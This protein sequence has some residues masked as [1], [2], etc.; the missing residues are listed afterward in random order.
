MA[1][2]VKRPSTAPARRTTALAA[3]GDTSTTNLVFGIVFEINGKQVPISTAD[4]AD[5]V[6]NGFEFTL[7]GPVDLGTIADLNTW[8]NT[9]WGVP[10][11]DPST[12]P[13]VLKNVW[14]KA[15]SLD[16][17]VAELHVKVP[18]KGSSDPVQFTFGMT[19]TWADPI[20]LLPVLK[21]G[22]IFAGATNEPK[23]SA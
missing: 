11:V 4:V 19:G 5:A 13:D 17:T 21:I 10:V 7:P 1:T 8:L 22:G 3:A 23:K 16:F 14:N 15:V 2:P 9:Q 20:V 6:K 12:W 18:P